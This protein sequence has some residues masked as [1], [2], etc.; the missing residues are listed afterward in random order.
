MKMK[1]FCGLAAALTFPTATWAQITINEIDADTPGNDAAEFIELHNPGETEVNLAGHILVLFNGNDD[2]SYEVIELLES[3]V[4]PAGGFFVLGNPGVPNVNIEIEPGANGFLQNGADA[5]ALYNGDTAANFDPNG[6]TLSP[7]TTDLVDAIVYGTSDSDDAE[8]LAGLGQSIQYDEDENGAKDTQSIQRNPDGSASFVVKEPTPGATNFAEPS[9]TVNFA[10][11]IVSEETGSFATLGEVV[12][13]G[14]LSEALTATVAI[15]S[16]DASRVSLST[17]TLNFAAEEDFAS[18]SVDTVDNAVVD[19]DPVLVFEVT[20]PGY[21]ASQGSLVVE[22]DEASFPTLVINEMLVKGSGGADTEF[23]ELFNNG[24]TAVDLAGYSLEV[25]ASNSRFSAGTLL[26]EI[27]I[28]SG[29]LAPGEFFTIANQ[30]LASVYGVTPDLE[31]ADL[32]INDFDITILLVNA[33]DEVV[34]STLSYDPDEEINVTANRAGEPVAPD[35]TVVD[36]GGFA[37][38]GYYLTE[39]GGEETGLIP[40]GPVS[41]PAPSAT[42]GASNVSP[43]LTLAVSADSVSEANSEGLTFT[44]TR[45]PDTTGEATVTLSSSD[46]GEL[47]VPASVTIL[48]GESSTS[49]V[50]T[51]VADSEI[52]G[53]QPVTVTATLDALTGQ[54]EVIVLDADAAG[55]QPCDILFAAAVSDTP[56]LF[57]FVAMVDLASGIQIKFTDNGWFAAGGFRSNEGV[58]TWTAPNEGVPAGTVVI[59]ED[60]AV[61]LG[62]IE[63]TDGSFNLAAGGDQLF[64]YQGD[65][66]APTFLA[67]LQMGTDWNEDATSPNTSALPADLLSGGA[68]ALGS[69]A[70]NAVYTGPTTGSPAELKAALTEAANYTTGDNREDVDASALP[71]AFLF[72]EP[73]DYTVAISGCSYSGGEFVVTF[74][75]TGASDVYVSTDLQTWTPATAGAGVASGSY[76]DAAP[77]AGG[78]AF[79][80]I[81][82]AGTAA[83]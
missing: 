65:D 14:D 31:V 58:L 38:A 46:I 41:E 32:D 5:V 52:D 17:T 56:D 9:F 36:P 74:T 66:A 8:L 67:G 39:D 25:Y 1:S 21:Q 72:G 80:L 18:F 10:P 12:R 48:D 76:T 20:A 78:K 82:K 11:A 60:G 69:G 70:D 44:V 75:A 29:S 16:G 28:A 47:T 54:R 53:N 22:D 7:T 63:T 34:F 24:D 26:N 45:F 55:L 40:F 50:A 77:P 43:M 37:P 61:S 59:Y 49:F 83:P 51:P 33:A 73:S 35:I 81:Q 2:Q 13:G 71:G 30:H 19:A 23:V 68:F 62:T 6:G 79:Y 3:D 57:A 42:P 64:A 4:I 27:E 15:V